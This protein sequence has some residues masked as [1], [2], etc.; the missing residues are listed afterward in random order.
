[1]AK[2]IEADTLGEVEIEEISYWGAQTQRSLSNFCIG[3]EVFPKVFIQAFAIQK[4]AAALANRGIFENQYVDAIVAS[5]HEIIEGKHDDQFPLSVWQTGSGTQ[6]NM[7]INEVIANL[8]NERLGQAKGSKH[9]IHPNDHVNLGQS[10][11]DAFPTAMHIAI[12]IQSHKELLPGLEHFFKALE[13]KEKEF[14][15]IVKV[16][17]THLQDATPI[18]LGQVFS[19]YRAQVGHIIHQ[20]KQSLEDIYALA[21]GGTAVGTGLNTK[22][23]FIK[24]FV[25]EVVRIT[26]LPFSSA[27]NKFAAI[28][29]HDS[30]VGFSGV[31]NTAAA[32]F[33][34]ISNDIRM[35]ASGPRCGIGEIILPVNEPG[36]SIMPGKIN[37]TQAE[38]MTMVAAQ[39]MG[40]HVTVTIAGSNGHF[41]LNAF[42]P[43]IIYNVL[44]SIRLLA[45][46]AY[47]FTDK[48][49]VGIQANQ[50]SI[51]KN[52]DRSLMLV[53]ALTPHVGYERAAEIAKKAYEENKTLKQAA[54]EL[55]YI[56]N[57]EQFDLLVDP[58]KM[59]KLKI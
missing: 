38:A 16:G 18:T 11:N 23:T 49:L 36:S 13:G 1:M 22:A 53:T 55:S 58:E 3:E 31:L 33:M 39:V 26:S 59:V 57:E 15:N 29:T 7:N 6:T 12:A 8:A 21:Q 51:Q 44:Q 46:V 17:R 56:K 34:K 5:A 27:D 45:D 32:A 35:L 42:K 52:L 10:T 14:K 37:P 48:C 40:N 47:S 30:I 20:L 4:M 43:V 28:A 2:R 9:P 54:L 50:E 24:R 25:E 41:E 19:G